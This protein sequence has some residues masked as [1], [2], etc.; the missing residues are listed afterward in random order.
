MKCSGTL[1]IPTFSCK[2][3]TIITEDLEKEVNR[4]YK[5]HGRKDKFEESA[6]ACVYS[7]DMYLI[8]L[9]FDIEYLTHNTISH[10]VFHIV[11]NIQHDRNML[12]EESGA[13]LTGH[14]TEYVYKFLDKKKLEVK[15]G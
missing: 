6:E 8:Y 14:I 10:E 9:V 2:I 5:K 7:P 3:Q 11:N 1:N 15:H 13:W 12:D 4:L